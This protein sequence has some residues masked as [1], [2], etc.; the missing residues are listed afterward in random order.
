[1]SAVDTPLTRRARETIDTASAVLV[2]LGPE[3]RTLA[4]L[5]AATGKPQTTVHRHLSSFVD[6]GLAERTDHGW[7]LAGR[8]LTC[9]KPLTFWAGRWVCTNGQ[10][11][12]VPS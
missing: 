11:P 1:V 3:P 5:V 8:C 6:A 10:C 2:A 9:R 7:R 12:G 4:D